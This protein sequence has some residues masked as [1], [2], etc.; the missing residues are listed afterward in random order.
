[1]TLSTWRPFSILFGVLAVTSALACGASGQA[2]P[3]GTAATPPAAPSVKIFLVALED[4][5]ASGPTIGCDDS[6]VAVERR[7][8]SGAPS[9]V[10]ALGELLGIREPRYGQ[11]GLY[12]ALAQSD[13]RV[14]AVEQTSAGTVVRL[15]GTLRL[16]GACDAP[17]VDAQLR[18]TV[19]QF[20]STDPVRILVNDV[21]LEQVLSG[22]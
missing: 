22:K 16:G 8:I 6:L 1:V 19:R 15:T 2:G 11:S 12:S 18:E 17:R 13:L 4:R 3:A 10:T 14:A 5:G 7:L 21:P 20:P 9:P